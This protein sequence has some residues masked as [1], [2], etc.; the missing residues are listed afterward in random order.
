MIDRKSLDAAPL[1]VTKTVSNWV[2]V[3]FCLSV[4]H[5]DLTDWPGRRREEHPLETGKLFMED[6]IRQISSGKD[7]P[8]F[9]AIH[10]AAITRVIGGNSA[11][12]FGKT[13][14]KETPTTAS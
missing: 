5:T 11:R 13:R 2:K 8:A 4:S 9:F 7:R 1:R 12:A 6:F 14:P 3:P 10:E